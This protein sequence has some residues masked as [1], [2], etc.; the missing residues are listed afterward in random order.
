[1]VRGHPDRHEQITWFNRLRLFAAAGVA[2]VT[3]GA[4]ALGVLRE[5]TP[6]Y[7]LAGV[8][9]LVDL[10]YF[11]MFPRLR[12]AEARV[13]RRHVD[14]QIAI[15]LI[16]LS[17]M[18]HF[19]GGITNPF[20]L[21]YLFHTFIASLLRSARAALVVSTI[22]TGCIAALAF[23]EWT[24]VLAHRPIRAGFMDLDSASATAV[25]AVVAALGVTQYIT[26][27]FLA[28]ILRRLTR[29]EMELAG[30]RQQLGRSEKLAAI[31]TLAAGVAHEINNPIGVI[32]NKV[33]I[34]RHRIDDGDPQDDLRRE[35]DVIDR[36]TNRI[37][38]VTQGLLT[39]AKEGPFSL[40]PVAVNALAREA[41]ELVQAPFRSAQIELALALD[42]R[43][44]Q[45]MGSANHLLQVL[46]NILLNARDASPP[47]STVFVS[48]RRI[49]DRVA[50][51]IRD[52]GTGIPAELI[53][54]IFD[55]FFTTKDVDKG[56][57]L[58][59]AISH[60][61]VERHEGE[62]EV[63]STVGEGTTFV[64]TLPSP[65]P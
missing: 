60:G 65:T 43:D 57:G 25:T 45:V 8:T 33:E 35:L 36:H 17:A 26:V 24:G 56:T 38:N 51:E 42:P 48:T 28:N 6:L 15:D 16:L 47:G 64:V 20:V 53:P 54:K 39:F 13:L 46:I 23:L 27:Y 11:A 9:L 29:R 52:E 34:L 18:L 44:P 1:M 10:A 32:K 21:F 58:G 12:T 31:G 4:Q 63:A 19:S 55:P 61:I 22:A 7:V 40:R 49:D 50:L 30:V 41:A 2:L 14:L 59:L 3:A 62:I 5:A 37:G